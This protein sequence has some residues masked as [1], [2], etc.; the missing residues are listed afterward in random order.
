M[1][2]NQNNQNS[3]HALMRDCLNPY[4]QFGKKEQKLQKQMEKMLD[5]G[6]KSEEL[7]RR[8]ESKRLGAMFARALREGIEHDQNMQP[9][10][11]WYSMPPDTT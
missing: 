2:I 9:T 3:Q 7:E 5:D 4:L 10:S 8:R 1:N 11:R 6:C